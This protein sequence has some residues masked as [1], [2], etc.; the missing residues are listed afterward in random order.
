[1]VAALLAACALAIASSPVGRVLLVVSP[2]AALVDQPVS[3][4][5]SNLTPGS[6]VT[7]TATTIDQQGNR[8]RSTATFEADQDGYVVVPEAPS[9]RGTYRGKDGM[10]PFR[11]MRRVSTRMPLDQQVL[12]PATVSTVRFIASQRGQTVA[13]ATLT[14]RTQGVRIV[15]HKTTLAKDGFISCYYAPARAAKRSPA[16]VFI[17]G[18]SGGLPCGYV[19]SLLASHGYPT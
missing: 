9:L 5:V 14:R 12:F 2:R 17:G 3:I 13:T 8:W 1:M 7:L 10:G 6:T 19:Q 11:S 15:E 18:S 16:V 4:T